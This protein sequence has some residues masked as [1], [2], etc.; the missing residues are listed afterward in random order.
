MNAY[1]MHKPDGTRTDISSCGVC[2]KMARGET[3][4][5]ISEKCCTCYDCGL[6]LGEDDRQYANQKLYHRACESKRRSEGDA[7][8]MEK[9]ELVAEYDGPVYCEAAGH[10]SYGDGYFADVEEVAD[11]WECDHTEID[12]VPEFVYCCESTQVACLDLD[13]ILE[14]A[15]EEA[16]EDARDSLHGI[17][18]LYAAVDAFNKLNEGVISWSP[19]Y[20]RKVAV[21]R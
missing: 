6:P 8:T 5:D 13:N 3:N 15:C 21:P 18:E 16:H 7:A 2:G 20:K 12:P 4:F 10:G 17:T 19:D 14:N 1:Y 11:A 9:A